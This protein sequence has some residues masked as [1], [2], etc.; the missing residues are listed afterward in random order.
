MDRIKELLRE[1][2]GWHI[3]RRHGWPTQAPFVTERVQ[4]SN[5]STDTYNEMPEDITRLNIEIERLAPVHKKILRLE[6]LDN[7]PQK[8]KAAELG[9]PR[10]VFSVRLRFIHEQLSHAMGCCV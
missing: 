10:E 3:D 1:W 6:Y 9:I 4:T 5:R 7:R 8:T 2:A